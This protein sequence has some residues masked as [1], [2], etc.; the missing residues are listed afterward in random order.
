MWNTNIV[1]SDE[2]RPNESLVNCHRFVSEGFNNFLTVR[3]QRKT[4]QRK[5]RY[6]VTKIDFVQI[7]LKQN[8]LKSP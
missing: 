6:P 3:H 2:H 7:W 5:S 1:R 8:S 4:L